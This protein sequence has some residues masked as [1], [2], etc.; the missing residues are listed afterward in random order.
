MATLGAVGSKLKS[1]WIAHNRKISPLECA[2]P[3]LKLALIVFEKTL[4]GVPIPGIKG[5]VGGILE[6]A[7]NEEVSIT[8]ANLVLLVLKTA[9]ASI[10]NAQDVLELQKQVTKLTSILKRWGGLH[11]LPPDLERRIK[12]FFSD[13]FTISTQLHDLTSRSAFHRFFTA[14]DDTGKI[15][16]L[17]REFDQVMQTFQLDGIVANELAIYRGFRDIRHA[18][19]EDN[20]QHADALVDAIRDINTADP[21]SSLPRAKN[22]RFNSSK[23]QNQSGCLENTRVDLLRDI[24]L[25]MRILIPVRRGCLCS[26]DLPGPVNRQSHP[27]CA[28]PSRSV[29]CLGP[30]SSSLEMRQA[31]PTRSLSSQPSRT[32]WLV[33]TRHLWPV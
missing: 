12:K 23:R 33:N 3:A 24:S 2:W 16:Q 25:W 29:G 1:K 28:R 6:L 18:V 21:V 4:D 14:G 30:A 27:L 17:L 20:L 11:E 22:A 19:R 31:P 26:R 9:Q 7:K 13:L 32:K 8:A 5:S 15:T 10:Q